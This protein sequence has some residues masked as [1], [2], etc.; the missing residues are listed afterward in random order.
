[1]ILRCYEN[2]SIFIFRVR[3]LQATKSSHITKY[4]SRLLPNFNKV[5]APFD[6]EQQNT[7]SQISQLI[8]TYDSYLVRV[9]P[10]SSLEFVMNVYPLWI[11]LRIIPMC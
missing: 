6:T 8:A 11:D 7:Y 10:E 9:E 4:L 2:T 5:E 3:C 1:M